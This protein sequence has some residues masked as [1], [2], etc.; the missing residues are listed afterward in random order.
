MPVT[1]EIVAAW[2]V[3]EAKRKEDV[4]T[5]KQEATRRPP[6]AIDPD[7]HNPF[8]PLSG[9]PR[10]WYSRT[11]DGEYRFYDNPGFDPQ[12]GEPLV[13]VTQDALDDWRESRS[14]RTATKCYIITRD[15]QQPV[16]YGSKPGIDAATGRECRELTP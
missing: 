15:P 3:Q 6:Q 14:E 12:S 5:S 1:K 7:Q 13:I 9:K 11:K 4:A 8:D 10:V 2:H 16:R